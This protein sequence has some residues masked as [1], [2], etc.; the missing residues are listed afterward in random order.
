MDVKN[1]FIARDLLYLSGA[2]LGITVGYILSLS[3]KNINARSRSRRIT[4]IFLA[5]SGVL[6]AFAASVAVSCGG[7]FSAGKLFFLAAACA[8]VFALAVYFPRAAAYPLVLAGGLLAV[9]LG[10]S[11]LR[12]PPAGGADAPLA[13]VYHEGANV[14]S[15]RLPGGAAGEDGRAAVFQIS[16]NQPALTVEGVRVGFPPYCPLIGGADRGLAALIRRGNTVLHEDRRLDNPGMQNWYARLGAWGIVF[17]KAA[18]TV[19]LDAIPR[20]ATMAVFFAG[21]ALS[22]RLVR[23][24]P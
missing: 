15:I 17:Q 8:P 23:P 3:K 22:S 2:F 18:G 14:Y 20:G 11:F 4:L 6:A 1:F 5:F 24:S 13:Y 16:G 7:I 19:P 12:F 21:D 9:W 10:Y